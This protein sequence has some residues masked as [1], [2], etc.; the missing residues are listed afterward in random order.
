MAELER[1]A[2]EYRDAAEELAGYG[3]GFL[4]ALGAHASWTS[5]ATHAVLPL[6]ATDLGVSLQLETGVA[7]HRRRFGDWIGGF[8]LPECAHAPWL[9]PLL[10][11]SGVRATCVEL[12]RTGSASAIPGTCRPLATDAGPVLWPI[13]RATMALVWSE[14]GYPARA[15]YRDYHRLSEHHHHL[16]SNDGQVYDPGAGGAAGGR[17]RPG[18]RRRGAS[19]GQR[20]RDLGMR[21]GHRAA[22]PLVVRGHGLAG[23]GDRGGRPSGAAA[24]QARRRARRRS[25]RSPLRRGAAGHPAGAR[26][27]TCA[28]G[29]GRRSPTWRG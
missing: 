15:A 20:R 18:L 12:T 29:A 5:S 24:G 22:R 2:Q 11:A 28:R 26:A 13:D 21:A 27:A 25:S 1:S 3:E 23:R 6:L 14:R 19:P 7:S 16:W 4:D 9:D 17:G 10:A 8:W